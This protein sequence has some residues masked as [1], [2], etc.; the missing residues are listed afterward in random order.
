MYIRKGCV[1]EATVFFLTCSSSRARSLLKA[2]FRDLCL[3]IDNIPV[4][5]AAH[6]CHRHSDAKSA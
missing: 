2:L 4:E 5:D 6:H 3:M 1:L